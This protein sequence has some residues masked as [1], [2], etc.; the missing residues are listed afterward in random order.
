MP[1]VKKGNKKNQ[2][3]V[4]GHPKGQTVD[5]KKA[6][7]APN[8]AS[9]KSVRVSQIDT[10]GSVELAKALTEYY[11]GGA[12]QGYKVEKRRNPDGSMELVIAPLSGNKRTFT[13]TYS[14]QPDAQGFVSGTLKV[15]DQHSFNVRFHPKLGKNYMTEEDFK[16]FVEFLTASGQS[17]GSDSQKGD[18]DQNKGV[19]E[20]TT[21]QFFNPFL[22]PTMPGANSATG[23]TSNAPTE[24]TPGFWEKFS[25][26][27]ANS[28]PF[29]ITLLL[30]NSN[31]SED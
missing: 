21:F 12:G 20:S 9:V 2:G 31:R 4:L 23:T 7:T 3:S 17:E 22:Q 1:T 10:T 19:P 29:L 25:D 18:S 27:L 15:D 6:S 8:D 30:M 13:I 14:G 16:K 11:G 26:S 24:R 28:L 5:P